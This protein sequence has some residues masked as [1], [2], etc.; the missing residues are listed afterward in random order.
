MARQKVSMY[1]LS[2]TEGNTSVL[3]KLKE[4][5]SLKYILAFF[6]YLPSASPL[7][8]SQCVSAARSDRSLL[9]SLVMEVQMLHIAFQGHSKSSKLQ[10]TNVISMHHV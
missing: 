5:L 1:N 9:T 8:C 4:L 6:Q 3:R 10:L 7:K 2:S